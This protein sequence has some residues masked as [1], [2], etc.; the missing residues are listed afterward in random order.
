MKIGI[1]PGHGKDGDPG[2]VG[3]S[4]LKESD[5]TLALAVQLGNFLLALGEEALICDR[6]LYSSERGAQASREG[7]DILISLHT[8]SGSPQA[9]GMEAWFAH[10]NEEG[11][12]L[13]GSVLGVL[14][15]ETGAVSRGI[16]D[17]EDWRP[18]NDPTWKGGMGVLRSFRGPGVLLEIMFISNPEEEKLL[19]SSEFLK[20]C[21]YAMAL[22]TRDFINSGRKGSGGNGGLKGGSA[23]ESSPEG[24]DGSPG[25][26]GSPF[27]D[28]LGSGSPGS[29]GHSSCQAPTSSFSSS[30]ELSSGGGPSSIREP[31]PDLSPTLWE[32]KARKMVLALRDLGIIR[33]YEDGSFRPDQPI[34]RM[35]AASMIYKALA[36]LGKLPPLD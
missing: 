5:V 19:R 16:K 30:G 2:A 33:G 9:K 10:G 24:K 21:A 32:G 1:D 26:A 35:E 8:N 31:F 28:G 14:V 34:T 6:N 25:C 7:C 18:G 23:G 12:R 15:S 22:G 20:R 17:D 13:A 4:G 3:P 27:S 36:Y 29:E 11:K